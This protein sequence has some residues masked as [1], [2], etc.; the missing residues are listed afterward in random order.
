MTRYPFAWD[1]REHAPGIHVFEPRGALYGSDDCYRFQ[2]HLRGLVA[3][4]RT[5]VIDLSKLERIDSCGVGILV[6]IL[7]SARGG[8]GQLMLAGANTHVESVLRHTWV[9]SL[10]RHAPT[11][12]EALST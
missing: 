5:V 12:D 8:S 1:T 4:G 9:L 11:V 10:I 7:A 3:A 6:A 2:D